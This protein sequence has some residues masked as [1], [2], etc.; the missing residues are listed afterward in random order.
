M[1]RIYMTLITLIGVS[2]VI[3]FAGQATTAQAGK[4]FANK[5]LTGVYYYTVQQIVQE[6]IGDPSVTVINYCNGYGTITF[7]GDGTA[8]RSGTDVCSIRGTS[9]ES[10]A[11]TYEVNPD[12]SF[13]I[14]DAEDPTDRTRGQIVNKGNMLLIDGTERNLEDQMSF[15]AVAAK[16]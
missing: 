7:Y 16:Q 11:L 1:K 9:I 5:N 10:Q 13:F 2:V 15:H 6:E 12:G 3:F 8:T 14:M 4:T